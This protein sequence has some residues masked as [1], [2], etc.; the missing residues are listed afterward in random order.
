MKDWIDATDDLLKFRRKEILNNS[1][2]ISQKGAIEKCEKEY[3]K[4]RVIQE[5]K[6]SSSMD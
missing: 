4:V 5:Q 2:S 6:Y 1:G 3:E